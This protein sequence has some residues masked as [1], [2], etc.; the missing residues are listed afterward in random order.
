MLDSIFKALD[1]PT[2]RKILDLLRRGDLTAGAIA[3]QFQ[4]S[5]P[6]ISHH[7]D[8][9]K[10]ADL[11]LA[12]R[13]GQFIIYSLNTTV[14]D[15]CIVWLLKLKEKGS[16]RAPSKKRMASTGNSPHPILRRRPALG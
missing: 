11:I 13:R 15:D 12:E 7:L 16:R 1:D 2:R 4:V 10:Q 9:L 14:V 6:T 3:D 8:L 5:K